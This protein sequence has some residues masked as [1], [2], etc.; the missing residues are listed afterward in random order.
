MNDS[1]PGRFARSVE[2]GCRSVRHAD[3]T[4]QEPQRSHAC[5]AWQSSRR[6]SSP[7]PSPGPTPCSRS[8][9]STASGG[10]TPRTPW[11]WEAIRIARRPSSSRRTPTISTPRAQF[12]YPPNVPP[13]CITRPSWPSLLKSGGVNIAVDRALDHVYGYALALD[14]TRRDLQGE[15]KKLRRPWEIG[16]A[17]ERSA[18]VGPVHPASAVGPSVRR[19]D[20]A[21][22]QRR[23]PPGRRPRPDDLE[24]CRR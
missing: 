14:M 21:E 9:G 1:R 3:R 8:A 19:Q 12:P 6:R 4:G 18:P 24:E 17:F 13:T 20:R 22:G 23:A 7:C 10:T 5:P 15:Q 2:N 11:R 16:K